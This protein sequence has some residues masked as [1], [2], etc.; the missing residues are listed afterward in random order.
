MQ[1]QHP[2]ILKLYLTDVTTFIF[3]LLSGIG[4]KITLLTLVFIGTSSTSSIDEIAFSSLLVDL[5]VNLSNFN[6]IFLALGLRINSTS[7]LIGV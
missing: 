5:T 3:L 6:F 2:M 4:L 1:F 7:S